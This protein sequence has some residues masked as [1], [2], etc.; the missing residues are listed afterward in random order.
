VRPAY[1]LTDLDDAY[2][3]L[4]EDANVRWVPP[5]REP[6]AFGRLAVIV[7]WLR[8]PGGDKKPTGDEALA[9]LTIL[10]SL[11]DWLA[12]AEPMLIDAARAGGVTWQQ[13]AG[14]LRVGDRRAAQRR[15]ARLA[16]A[17]LQ[18]R[19]AE[20]PP[21]HRSPPTLDAYDLLISRGQR[22]RPASRHPHPDR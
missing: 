8:W 7:S 16:T 13:L 21:D 15:A 3:F 1:D 22:A 6:H 20:L 17:A 5:G 19:I 12:E 9:A 2:R 14:V 4:E 10:A 18:R 11:R